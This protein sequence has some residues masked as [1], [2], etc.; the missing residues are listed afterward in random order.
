MLL[1]KAPGEAEK[2]NDKLVEWKR[3]KPQKN[4]K[5]ILP[6]LERKTCI[7][8]PDLPTLK[9]FYTYYYP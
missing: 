1:S 6:C 2:C 5:R 4:Q 3:R 9:D 7:R 8:Q